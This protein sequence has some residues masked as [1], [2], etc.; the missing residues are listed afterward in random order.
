MLAAII[1]QNILNP[2]AAVAEGQ[3]WGRKAAPGELPELRFCSDIYWA[4][5]VRRNPDIKNLRVY[6]AQQVINP[7]TVLLTS[8]AFKNSKIDKLSPWPG[9]AFLHGSEE[10]TA[11]LGMSSSCSPGCAF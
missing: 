4:Y 3:N 7:D 1:A 8:R 9:K 5:W 10:L 11:L 6:G 2:A